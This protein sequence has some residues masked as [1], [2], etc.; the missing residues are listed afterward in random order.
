MPM[1]HLKRAAELQM[2]RPAPGW[3]SVKHDGSN[4]KQRTEKQEDG[5]QLGRYSY[6]S[7]DDLLHGA[8]CFLVTCKFRKYVWSQ[9][10]RH[11]IVTTAPAVTGLLQLKLVWLG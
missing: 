2:R 7:P 3:D 1:E 8:K 6:T 11:W 9:R 4:K 5:G 10:A